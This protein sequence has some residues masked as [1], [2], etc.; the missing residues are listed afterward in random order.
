[1]TT[2]VRCTSSATAC[3]CSSTA[4]SPACSPGI[5]RRRRS[6]CA[7]S[8]A[9]RS[10]ARTFRSRWPRQS[11]RRRSDDPLIRIAELLDPSLP[12]EQWPLLKQ[13]GIDEVVSLLDE[14]EQGVRWLR[15]ESHRDQR[16][17]SVS[18]G[19]NGHSWGRDALERLNARYEES[20]FS[21]VAIEDTP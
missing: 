8:P 11:S 1:A 2:C 19:A 21:L 16:P 6:S 20:G 5:R 9:S 17:D 3:T 14:G 12:L 13:V 18:L 10:R 7:G 4:G 15:S